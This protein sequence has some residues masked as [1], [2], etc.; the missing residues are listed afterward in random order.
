MAERLPWGVFRCRHAPLELPPDLAAALAA[1]YA[2]PQRAYHTAEHV[3][4]VL[5][6]FDAVADDVGWRQPREVYVAI[7]FHDA[8]YFP[9]ASNN[10]T[11]SAAWAR[12]AG[13]PVDGDRVAEL[14]ELTARH[15]HV[16]SADHDAAHFLD[17]D[18]AILGADPV[19]FDRYDAGIA[20]EYRHAPRVPYFAGR[21]A[22]LA[23]L[24]A[25]P[26]IFLTEYF[27][28]RL[29]AAARANLSRALARLDAV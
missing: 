16:E 27:H 26:R 21:R 10:E 18:M 22:F 3:A 19:A 4:E 28:A 14:V 1:A 8:V 12:S 23:R 29:D 7:V 11:R 9:G 17:A 5:G 20:A 6:W 24:A 13:L 25:S 2:E 15:G